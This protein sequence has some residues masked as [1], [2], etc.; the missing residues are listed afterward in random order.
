VGDGGLRCSLTMPSSADFWPSHFGLHV[1]AI[2]VDT[3]AILMLQQCGCTRR[4]VARK[5]GNHISDERRSKITN[6]SMASNGFQ[7]RIVNHV[8]T[9]CTNELPLKEHL[10]VLRGPGAVLDNAAGL[11]NWETGLVYL[12]SICVCLQSR[13][14]LHD[15]SLQR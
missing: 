2:Y 9:A 13:T 15:W 8:W 1:G 3:Q 4:C 11:V 14:I 5:G 10:P 6:H 7:E 12:A